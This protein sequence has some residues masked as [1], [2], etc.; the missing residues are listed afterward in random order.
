VELLPLSKDAYSGADRV[1]RLAEVYVMVGE[2]DAA[3]DKLELLL[4]VPSL[5]S[6]PMLQI[7]PLFDP[8]R[9]RPRFQA[10]LEEYE[11]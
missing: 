3:I 4:S 7:D 8:L 11:Q 6:V 10:L 5:V 1:E 9:D 2:Y